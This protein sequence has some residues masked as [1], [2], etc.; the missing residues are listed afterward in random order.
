MNPEQVVAE[1]SRGAGLSHFLVAATIRVEDSYAG[2]LLTLP[3]ECVV[4]T[5]FDDPLDAAI[6]LYAEYRVNST[7]L[8]IDMLRHTLWGEIA[9]PRSML[10]SPSPSRWLHDRGDEILRRM[11]FPPGRL[12]RAMASDNGAEFALA[13]LRTALADDPSPLNG[14]WAAR[15]VC[16]ARRAE[17]LSDLPAALVSGLIDA[18]EG[19]GELPGRDALVDLRRNLAPDL[20]DRLT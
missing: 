8:S 12:V 19:L 3:R 1:A 9:V 15:C 6:H 18:V 10:G 14:A 16:A 2:D 13:E 7:A 20:L 5:A 4:F 11:G 17:A